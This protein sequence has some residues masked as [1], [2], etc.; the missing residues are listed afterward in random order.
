MASRNL[1]ANKA[2][3]EDIEGLVIQRV[4]GLEAAG[5]RDA[6]HDAVAVSAIG[7]QPA[8]GLRLGSI[9]VLEAGTRVEI[10]AAR[11]RVSA[12]TEERDGLWLFKRDQH[13]RLVDRAESYLLAVYADAPSAGGEIRALLLV[14]ASVIDEL[15]SGRWYTVDRCE[16]EIAQLPWSTVLD[17]GGGDG[18]A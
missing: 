5:E 18:G 7:P 15:L 17:V 10:K 16:G 1:A 6:Y 9:C 2:L 3:G 14:P 8:V 12:G 13:D 11:R 4:A